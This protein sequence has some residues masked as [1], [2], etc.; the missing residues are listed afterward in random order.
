MD[1]WPWMVQSFEKFPNAIF[2]EDIKNFFYGVTQMGL[3][4]HQIFF[5][6]FFSIIMVARGVQS[7]CIL[8]ATTDPLIEQWLK[9]LCLFTPNIWWTNA[10]NIKSISWAFSELLPFNWNF[11]AKTLNSSSDHNCWKTFLKKI[12]LRF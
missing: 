12:L 9:F 2:F 6:N 8:E 3:E 4:S 7:F 10:E 1:H 11:L 5:H